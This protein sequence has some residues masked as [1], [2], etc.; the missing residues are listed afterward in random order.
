MSSHVRIRVSFSFAH[1]APLL[2]VAMLLLAG[3]GKL[4]AKLEGQ[5]EEPAADPAVAEPMAPPPDAGKPVTVEVTPQE[6]VAGFLALPAQQKNDD[7]LLAAAQHAA[8]VAAVQELVLAGSGVTDS[9]AAVLPK[10][11]ALKRLDLS[12]ARLSAKSLETVAQ[13]SSLESLKINALP[14]EDA[15]IATLKPL[16]ALMELSLAGTSIGESAFDS[17]AA[18]EQ[19]HVLDVSGNDQV[20]GRSFSELVK[21]KRFGGLVLLHADNSGFGYY[22]LVEIGKLPQL[23][24]LSV[25]RSFVGDDALKGLEKSKSLKRVHLSSNLITDA[26]MPSFKRMTQLEELR[27]DGNLAI[28]DAG[29]KELRGLKQLKELRLDGTQC[30]LKEVQSLKSSLPSTTIYFGGQKL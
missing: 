30:T 8:E 15:A 18:M 21:Q 14:L 20:L 12:G 10:F 26:G 9:G 29:L 19:L 22:G 16:P 2:L 3:C 13:L 28:T 23:E 4:K 5:P 27:L 17:L 24:F 11:S 6:V 1:G 7:N 25:G